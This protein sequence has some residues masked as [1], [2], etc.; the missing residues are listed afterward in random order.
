MPP[1][2][3]PTHTHNM[4]NRRAQGHR[5]KC[6][7]RLRDPRNPRSGKWSSNGVE[8][9]TM[10]ILP[11]SGSP[12]VLEFPWTP[13][14]MCLQYVSRKIKAIFRGEDVLKNSTQSSS[15]IARKHVAQVVVPGKR[16]ERSGVIMYHLIA[17][18]I[19]ILTMNVGKRFWYFYENLLLHICHFGVLRYNIEN[20]GKWGTMPR[21]IREIQR[22]R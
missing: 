4:T 2:P 19:I 6:I 20:V 11:S 8:S 15:N 7:H 1:P 21:F 17:T 14:T 18:G 9:Y 22:R 10:Y 13:M 5:L 3:P 12:V 16:H